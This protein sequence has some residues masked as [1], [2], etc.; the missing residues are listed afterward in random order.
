MEAVT[1]L[2]SNHKLVL[3]YQQRLNH[4]SYTQSPKRPNQEK[5]KGKGKDSLKVYMRQQ[6][7]K[8]GVTQLDIFNKLWLESS[9]Q[10]IVLCGLD[11]LGRLLNNI[12]R[13]WKRDLQKLIDLGLMRYIHLDSEKPI[14]KGLRYQAVLMIDPKINFAITWWTHRYFMEVVKQA[15]SLRLLVD[16]LYPTELESVSAK[17]TCVSQYSRA[18]A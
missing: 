7:L 1:Y 16:V 3:A 5:A 18:V 8:L 11:K 6:K 15:W 4:S 10:G 13:N 17:V 14:Y 12:S 9:A 2:N